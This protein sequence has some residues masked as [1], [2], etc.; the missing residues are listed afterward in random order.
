MDLKTACQ[1]LK[2]NKPQLTKKYKMKSLGIFGSYSRGEQK[3]G[4]DLDI[5]VEYRE[6][7]G[8]FGL[9][10]AEEHIGK[11]LGVKVV[12]IATHFEETLGQIRLESVSAGWLIFGQGFDTGWFRAFVKRVFDIVCASILIVLTLPIMLA[13]ALL[14]MLVDGLPVLYLQERVGQNGRLFNVIKF[15]SMRKDAEKDGQPRWATAGDDRCIRCGK[16]IRKLRIDELPQLFSVLAGYM[17]M[18]GPR[19]ERAYFVDQL[20]RE[21]PYYAIRHS[22]KPGVTGW[23]Q[24]RYQY[25]SSVEDAAEK[26]QYDLYYVKNHSLFLDIVVMFETIGVVL[27]RKGAQ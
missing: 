24:V 6:T 2:A 19:P 12:D 10:D 27:M 26:L 23:A 11:L 21:I 5:L 14:I 22:I 17:S 9:L 25:G 20:T 1:I 3:K 7:P 18:V 13:T 16:L 15:R 8:F 4:S